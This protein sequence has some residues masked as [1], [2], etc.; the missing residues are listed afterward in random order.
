MCRSHS[1]SLRG[2]GAAPALGSVAAGTR[3]GAAPRAGAAGAAVA[4]VGSG[5]GILAAVWSRSISLA[6]GRAALVGAKAG[7]SSGGGAGITWAQRPLG[8]TLQQQGSRPISTLR[9]RRKKLNKHKLKKRR[10]LARRS[11]KNR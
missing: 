3:A 10:K 7:G 4:G 2:A 6:A 11:Q 8:R 1:L 5:N 9:R